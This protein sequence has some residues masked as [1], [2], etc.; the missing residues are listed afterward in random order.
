VSSDRKIKAN[1]ANARLSRGPKSSQGRARSS[2]N[3]RQHGLT[4]P[5]LLDPTWS[6]E[7]NYLAQKIVGPRASPQC[8]ERACVIAEAV[9]DLGRI[10]SARHKI[11]ADA[12]ND[13]L[14]PEATEISM[15]VLKRPAPQGPTKLAIMLNEAAKNLFATRYERRALSRRK[16]AIREF[17]A[18][19][20][21]GHKANAPE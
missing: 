9:I 8:Q 19:R 17:D 18:M 16:R 7:V 11:L 4:V 2:K 10:R 13:G 21:D 1:R 14:L 3:A 12:L 15:D 20:G 5:I 6:G